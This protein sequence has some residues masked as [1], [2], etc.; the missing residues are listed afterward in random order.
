[1][2]R[3]WAER[4]YQLRKKKGKFINDWGAYLNNLNGKKKRE[5]QLSLIFIKWVQVE[6]DQKDR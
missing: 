6:V 4:K 3:K 1:M 5:N 2:E